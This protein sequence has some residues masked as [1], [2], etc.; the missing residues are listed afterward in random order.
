MGDLALTTTRIGT[1]STAE[2]VRR[3]DDGTWCWVIDR[4]DMLIASVL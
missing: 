1:T 2:V 3:Q 4:P